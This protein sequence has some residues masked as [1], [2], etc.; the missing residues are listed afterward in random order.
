MI[1]WRGNCH[2]CKAQMLFLHIPVS[3]ALAG[4][5]SGSNVLDFFQGRL[6]FSTLAH[7]LCLSFHVSGK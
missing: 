4:K 5:L 3:N 6:V 2:A 1:L 7:L